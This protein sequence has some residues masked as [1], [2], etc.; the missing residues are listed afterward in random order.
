MV[1]PWESQTN[2]PLQENTHTF[3]ERLFSW[4]IPMLTIMLLFP[5]FPNYKCNYHI[6]LAHF[7]KTV[8]LA[9]PESDE[10]EN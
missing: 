10:S 9:F 4:T 2:T 5:I 7:I 6:P 1:P 8:F 3:W